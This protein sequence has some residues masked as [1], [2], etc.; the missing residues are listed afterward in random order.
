MNLM[1]FYCTLE[2]KLKTYWPSPSV[3]AFV[4]LFSFSSPWFSFSKPICLTFAL[5]WK[6]SIQLFVLAR[7]PCIT[8]PGSKKSLRQGSE[9][10]IRA[11]P[12]ISSATKA[13]MP[14]P[15]LPFSLKAC[16]IWGMMENSRTR[17]LKVARYDMTTFWVVGSSCQRSKT[18]A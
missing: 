5:I 9:A 11:F 10:V 15:N 13:K 18:R 8:H 6:E 14:F 17:K 12:K 2:E 16:L 1:W 3:A 4:C 7:C